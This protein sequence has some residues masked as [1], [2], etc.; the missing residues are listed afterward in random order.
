MNKSNTLLLAILATQLLLTIFLYFG[1]NDNKSYLVKTN[2]LAV[3]FNAIDEITITDASKQELKLSQSLQQWQ[4]PDYYAIVVNTEKLNRVSESL[5]AIKSGW[6]IASTESAASRFKVAKDKFERRIT[7]SQ[8]GKIVEDLYLGISLDLRK[9]YVRRANHAEIYNVEFSTFELSTKGKDWATKDLLRIAVDDL[10][11]IKIHNIVL[12]HKENK[13]QLD[14]LDKSQQTSLVP[15]NK[16]IKALSNLVYTEIVG[17]TEPTEY[18]LRKHVMVI[19]TT[20]KKGASNQLSFA[21]V[22]ADNYIAK[23]SLYPYYF[24]ISQFKL[25]SLLDISRQQLITQKNL[26]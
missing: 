9:V 1:A 3:D 10:A 17:T 22:N 12:A 6:P 4:L 5:L 16:L 2:Y 23:S 11:Q 20:S 25:K 26:E 13:W 8:K 7:F 21:K 19:E 24:K 14:N 15:T 18:R